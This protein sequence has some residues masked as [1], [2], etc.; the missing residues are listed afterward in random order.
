MVLSQHSTVCFVS[1]WYHDSTDPDNFQKNFD[2]ASLVVNYHQTTA[3]LCQWQS[4]EGVTKVDK[5][6]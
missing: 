5:L 4:H 1:V 2:G 3:G 6:Q